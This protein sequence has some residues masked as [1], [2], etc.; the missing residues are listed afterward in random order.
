MKKAG[1]EVSTPA[2][3]GKASDYSDQ[4]LRYSRLIH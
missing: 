4:P 1:V 2:F 3:P